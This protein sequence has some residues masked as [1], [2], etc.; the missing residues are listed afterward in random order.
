MRRHG[1][2]DSVRPVT[3]RLSRP[4]AVDAAIIVLAIALVQFE[5]WTADTVPGPR[6]GRAL[7]LLL[8]LVVPLAV[9][10]TRPLLAAALVMGALDAYC[11][12]HGSPEGT[13]VIGPVAVVS[14]SVAA[15]SSR[16]RAF[17]GLALLV[18]AYT[19]YAAYDPN[20][21]QHGPLAAENEWAAAFFGAAVIAL[22]LAGI[23]MR[24]RRDAMQLARRTEAAELEA[25]AAVGEER[26]RMAREL[27]D[28]VSHNLSVVVLQAAGAR[29]S[30]A[31]DDALEKIERSGREALVEM[32]RLLGV[33]REDGNDAALEPQPGIAS[34]GALVSGVRA[35]GAHG[36]ARAGRRLGRAAARARALRLSHRAGGV[37]EHP[38][39]RTGG[40]CHRPRAT[41]SGV[42]RRR[43]RG[44][45]TRE[46]T[47]ERRRARPARDGG[48]RRALSRR[49]R[50]RP[51]GR[52]RLR[53]HA[54]SS[55]L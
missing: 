31:G 38:A 46:C 29:A 35:A 6:L 26:A 25:E 52:R 11:V 3:L 1:Q 14:Y 54:R 42:D 39:A 28:I 30:G 37:D 19:V 20:V 32:R 22:W 4:A 15:F 21:T 34:L 33:L 7:P 17:A 16:R 55:P 45:R 10:R 53:R 41:A 48:A 13:E 23:Y 18:A 50:D 8:L 44:R 24:S 12:W 47:G 36:A 5:I 27:H 40:A 2:G 49:A 51:A 9:R 43:S